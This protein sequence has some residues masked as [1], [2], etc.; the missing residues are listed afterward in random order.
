MVKRLGAWYE[1]NEMLIESSLAVAGL[2]ACIVA[3][4]GI[5]AAAAVGTAVAGGVLVGSKTY[6]QTGVVSESLVRGIAATSINVLAGKY[7]SAKVGANHAVR[8]FGKITTSTGRVVQ[9]HYR[10]TLR[11][12]KTGAGRARASRQVYAATG[13]S[14][15]T[16]LFGYTLQVEPVSSP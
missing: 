6:N 10:T 12:L 1:R 13:S 4:A 5:C 11:A 2:A 15:V 3:T 14:A 16:R 9:R 8:E 7:V